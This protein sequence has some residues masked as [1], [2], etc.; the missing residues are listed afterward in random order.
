MG[1]YQ[2]DMEVRDYEC[3]MADGVNNSVYMSYLEHARHKYLASI[4]INFA[5]FARKKIGL[6]VIR[7]ELDFKLS[8]MS[9]DEFTVSVEMERVSKLRF[10]FN[11]EIHRKKDGKLVLAGKI[12]GTAVGENGRPT[13]PEEIERIVGEVAATAA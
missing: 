8:L 1:K 10:A 3:D 4:G 12:F 2:I 9:G 13:M 6:I 11:Q 7:A 5:E